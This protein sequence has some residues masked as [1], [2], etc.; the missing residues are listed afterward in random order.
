MFGASQLFRALANKETI[1]KLVMLEL[2]LHAKFAR[3]RSMR[4]IWEPKGV[5]V[6]A[7]QSSG[8]SRGVLVKTSLSRRL[9]PGI[10][11]TVS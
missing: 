9:S 4:R 2:E 11:E 7:C 5:F 6:R 8:V 10:L 1:L 3:M